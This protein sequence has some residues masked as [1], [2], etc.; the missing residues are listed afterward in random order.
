VLQMSSQ[1]EPPRK[2]HRAVLGNLTNVSV[3]CKVD[4][5]CWLLC[6]TVNKVQCILEL[7]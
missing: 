4:I 2:R 7:L 1:D 6:N 5:A 3:H